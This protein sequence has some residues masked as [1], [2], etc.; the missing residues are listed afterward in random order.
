M[1]DLMILK[2]I[3]IL[4]GFFGLQLGFISLIS[5]RLS[6]TLYQLLMKFFNWKV[7]PIHW[8]RELLTTQ[9]LGAMIVL[10]CFAM[11]VFVLRM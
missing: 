2:I 5:P 10:L 8:K 3:L 6:I 4:I 9:I 11:L 7:E 1:N